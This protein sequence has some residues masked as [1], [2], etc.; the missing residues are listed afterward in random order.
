VAAAGAPPRSING[1]FLH[2]HV[3][4]FASPTAPLTDIDTD[5]DSSNSN[6]NGNS[7][8]KSEL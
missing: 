1:V 4:P 6:S 3:S 7:D 2:D 5:T 8:V